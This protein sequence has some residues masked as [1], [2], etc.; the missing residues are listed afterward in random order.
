MVGQS[1]GANKKSYLQFAKEFG[2]GFG[3][4]ALLDAI[5]EVTKMPVLNDQAPIGGPGTSNFELIG[6]GVSALGASLGALSLLTGKDYQFAGVGK[7]LFSS[8]LGSMLGIN[9]YEH[10]LAE[11][12]GIR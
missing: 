10:V 7:A 9:I 6:Y 11:K 12:L 2:A 8:G 5:V 4:G 3:A 1:V